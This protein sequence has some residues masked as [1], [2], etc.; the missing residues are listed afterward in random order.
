MTL[1]FLVVLIVFALC[2][3]AEAQQPKKVSRIGFLIGA[4]ASSYATRIDAFRQGLKELGYIEGQNISIEYRYAEGNPDRLSKLATELVRLKVDAII[5]SGERAARAT[6]AATK[7]IP[8]I[9]ASGADPVATGLVANLAR[10]GGNVTGLTNF[11]ADLGPKRLELLKEVLPGLARVAV[12]PSPSATGRELKG[13]QAAAPGLKIQLQILKV[14]V[15][16]DFERAFKEAAN[17]HAGA[18][19]VNSDGTGLFI[20]NG[21]QIVE[22]AAKNRLPAIY[23]ASTYVNAAGGLMS[24]AANDIE[25]WRHAATYADKILKGAKPADLPVEQATK[26]EFIINLKAAK[27]IGLTIPETVLYRADKVIK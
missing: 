9:M 26:F 25:M 19:V 8:I 20:A 23:A 18:L 6:A 17:T 14:Q 3:F 12:L 5:A 15:A 7:T 16:E 1:R 13:M 10:P 2:S 11:S 21:R 4:S 24:Y 27:Q 22:L